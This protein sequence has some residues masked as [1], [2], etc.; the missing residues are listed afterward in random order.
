M[1]PDPLY[2]NKVCELII[3]NNLETPKILENEG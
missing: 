2:L 3:E 1:T